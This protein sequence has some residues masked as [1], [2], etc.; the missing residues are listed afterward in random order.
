MADLL[1]RCTELCRLRDRDAEI[2]LHRGADRLKAA[3]QRAE[4]AILAEGKRPENLSG[5]EL[6]R[7]I[8][9]AYDET[10]KI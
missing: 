4:K 6:L 10:K 7:R 9:E 1:L 5:D 2:L 3:V 8:S